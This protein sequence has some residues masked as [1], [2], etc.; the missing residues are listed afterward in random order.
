M[1]VTWADCPPSTAPWL[2]WYPPGL[3][4]TV[5]RGPYNSLS[6]L[7][8]GA[9]KTF[10]SRPAFTQGGATLRYED[11]E[12]VSHQLAAWLRDEVGLV[13]GDRL[14]VMLPNVVQYP[15]VVA[16]A[17]LAGLIVVNVNPLYTERELVHQL[18]DAQASAIVVLDSLLPLVRSVV[19]KTALRCVIP[20]TLT[21]LGQVGPAAETLPCE[22][23]ELPLA[24]GLKRP[25][26]VSFI[27]AVLSHDDVALLQYTGGTTGLSKGAMLTH[28][29]MLSGQA[30]A[31][32]WYGSELVP[33]EETVL[34]VLPLYHIF[35][36]AFNFLL[37][38]RFGAHN[39]LVANGRDMA[40]IVSA[41]ASGCSVITGVN[42]LFNALANEPAV[43]QLDFSRLKLS[44]S[45][46]AT[47]QVA[48]VERWQALT[49][50]RIS[51]GYGL[52]ETSPFAL[53]NPL[54]GGFGHGLLPMPGTDV[55]IRDEHGVQVPYGTVGEICIR[56]PQVMKG[57]WNQPQ[58]S[59]AVLSADGWLRTGDVGLMD[60]AG[61]VQVTDRKKDVVLV[62]GF[63]VYPNEVEG[64]LMQH[65]DVLECAVVGQPD[66]R[67]GEAVVAYVVPRSAALAADTLVAHCRTAL[68]AYKVPKKVLLVDQ[69]P[70]SAVGKILRRMLVT[71]KG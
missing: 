2:Q 3:P 60:D 28:G 57:Y 35:G 5:A 51:E 15:V 30:L 64:V 55:Q 4:A 47:T 50:V 52:T 25:C 49:G 41:L 26:P 40:E 27:P 67:T 46:G 56:G 68:T 22:A 31:A 61:R 66:E 14:A 12:R 10:A 58:E 62:S 44:C 24:A 38:V 8:Q 33:G 63:N 29:N 71:S 43:Q 1:S 11:L 65:P 13:P 21:D 17:W 39:R 19:A 42:T 23:D 70:K 18:G 6:E 48:V 36:L 53:S 16:A 69:L 45:G 59:V 9:C 34:T 32:A 37:M 20:T 7:V 54:S